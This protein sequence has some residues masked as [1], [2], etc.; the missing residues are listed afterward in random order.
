MEPSLYN[1][2]QRHQREFFCHM[3]RTNIRVGVQKNSTLH[4][5]YQETPKSHK[6]ERLIHTPR[7]TK[8]WESRKYDC[9]H[10]R[11]REWFL[12]QG[13]PSQW[14]IIQQPDKRITSNIKQRLQIIHD[15]VWS[16]IQLNPGGNIEEQRISWTVRRYHKNPNALKKQRD[17]PKNPHNGKRVPHN[18]QEILTQQ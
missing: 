8:K 3:E 14:K 17:K 12:H 10:T 1:L 2:D 4:H 16:W 15:N 11:P 13:H 5:N 7:Y 9:Y 6:E 18:R